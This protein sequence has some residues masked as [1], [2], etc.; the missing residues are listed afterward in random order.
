MLAWVLAAAA[1]NQLGLI[2]VDAAAASD[3]CRLQHLSK[4]CE[5]AA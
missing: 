5:L 4:H 1:A 2:D 3:Q